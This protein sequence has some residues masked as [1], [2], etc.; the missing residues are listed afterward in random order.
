VKEA[1]AIKNS[2]HHIRKRR[3]IVIFALVAAALALVVWRLQPTTSPLAAT[4]NSGAPSESSTPALLQDDT[5][6]KQ[7]KSNDKTASIAAL[8][9]RAPVK[10]VEEESFLA[11]IFKDFKNQTPE[12]CGLSA[13][14]AKAF[15][16]SN[17][18]F[19]SETTSRA[20][21]DATS[22]F[23]QSNNVHEKATGLYLFA[24]QA[25]G[26]AAESERVN[27]P[28]CESSDDCVLKPYQARQKAVPVNAEPLVTLALESNDIS[29]YATAL[30][31]CSGSTTGACAK[32]S[33]ARWA[34]MEPDNA[35]AWMMAAS[36]AEARKD[37]AARASA[38]QRAVSANDYNTRFPILTDVLV[39]DEIQDQPP[40]QL[41]STL[42]TIVGL[43]AA[44]T[45]GS[46]VGLGR[47]CARLEVMDEPRRVM[48]DALATKMAEKDETLFGVMMA[49][50]IGERS[51]WSAERLQPLK[52]EYEVFAGHA[53]E[54]MFGEKMFTCEAV[55]IGNQKLLHMLALGERG[56]T[57]EFVKQS[58]K[59]LAEMAAEY[60]KSAATVAK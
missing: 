51:G 35:A 36:E 30:Y 26:D 34:Q 20:L 3:I 39:S 10:P 22:K 6:N 7:V 46:L 15:I 17:G 9:S 2:P 56:A 55:S 41:A 43:N 16:A 49:K 52:D 45:I 12:V 37:S 54:G 50:S 58:G 4:A 53:F 59:T 40:M 19:F 24:L 14:E 28:G 47:H 29:V 23:V 5:A 57:R 32:I 18:M 31:A 21:A 42:S 13:A 25:G 48:C 27:Y 44:S 11:S 1:D 33:Y 60:R 8:T 38:L